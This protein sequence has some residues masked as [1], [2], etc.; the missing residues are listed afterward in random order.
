MNELN[1][2]MLTFAG[3]TAASYRNCPAETTDYGKKHPNAICHY[4]HPETKDIINSPPDF[5][6]DLNA[7]FKWLVPKLDIEEPQILCDLGQY[8][9][10]VSVY[11][12]D[13]GKSYDYINE[14]PTLAF[15]KAI[16]KLIDG[17]K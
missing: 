8:G 9:C 4:E 17:E 1:R 5:T 10:E 11:N 14:S 15:C 2:K 13:T 12:N 16:E 3:F 6:N 7:C